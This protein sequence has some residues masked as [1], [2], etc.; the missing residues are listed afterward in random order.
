MD[1]DL[2][3]WLE[4]EIDRLRQRHAG[5][6]REWAEAREMRAL[7]TFGGDVLRWH[8]VLE[9]VVEPDIDVEI[10]TGALIVRAR[11]LSECGGLFVCLLPVP[12][13]FDVMRPEIRCEQD[14]L[15]VCVYRTEGGRQ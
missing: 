9:D 15:E 12:S 10:V 11:A 5:F 14:Y 2:I 13:G 4:G 1:H 6:L 8:V 7:W 3:S